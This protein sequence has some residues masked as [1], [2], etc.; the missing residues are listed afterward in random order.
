MTHREYFEET[1]KDYSKKYYDKALKELNLKLEKTEEIE[2]MPASVNHPEY[3][4]SLTEIK[5]HLI[6]T[7]GEIDYFRISIDEE[8]LADDLDSYMIRDTLWHLARELELLM[9]FNEHL[10][11]N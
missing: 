10:K 7:K 1:F 11:E 6:G 5:L 9:K 2:K 3:E 4:H 8:R